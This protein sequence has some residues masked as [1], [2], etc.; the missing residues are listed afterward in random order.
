LFK[1]CDLLI[2]EVNDKAFTVEMTMGMEFPM[3]M[4]MPWN[5]E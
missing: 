5:G 2:F 3:G 1:I 4:R